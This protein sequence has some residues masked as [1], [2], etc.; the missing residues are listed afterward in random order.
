MLR[1]KREG[2]RYGKRMRHKASYTTLHCVCEFFS[3]R[4]RE[5]DEQKREETRELATERRGRKKER[6]RSGRD[7]DRHTD[8]QTELVHSCFLYIAAP[9]WT[10]SPCTLGS[11]FIELTEHMPYAVK[12][13]YY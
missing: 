11:Y 4:E 3:E 8:T 12:M 6:E 1:G 7:R 5:T 10:C 2:Q 9:L 13:E